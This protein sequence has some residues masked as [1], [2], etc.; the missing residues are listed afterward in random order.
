M[1]SLEGK[2]PAPSSGREGALGSSGG[3]LHIAY[4]D[5]DSWGSGGVAEIEPLRTLILTPP[6]PPDAQLR[7]AIKCMDI[8]YGWDSA[9]HGK[10]TLLI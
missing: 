1:N 7:I 9:A 2:D 3:R 5:S 8:R 6:C 4:R 10:G